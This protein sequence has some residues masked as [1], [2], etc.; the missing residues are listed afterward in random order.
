MLVLVR[1]GEKSVR[2]SPDDRL[3]NVKAFRLLNAVAAG[4]SAVVRPLGQAAAF[5]RLA[6]RD[7]KSEA[8]LSLHRCGGPKKIVP[9]P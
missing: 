1:R 9:L 8:Y 2:I 5:C 7:K 3:F 6:G 4:I